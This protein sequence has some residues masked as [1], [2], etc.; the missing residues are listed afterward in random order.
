MSGKSNAPGP[1]ATPNLRRR[2]ISRAARGLIAAIGSDTRLHNRVLRGLLDRHLAPGVLCLV[3]FADH[4]LYVDPRDDKVALKLLSGRPWQRRELETAIALL[5]QAGRLKPDSVFIDVGANI[6]SQTVYAMRSGA[7]TRAIAIEP[8]P[9]NFEILKRNLAINAL[10]SR[11]T[12]LCAAASAAAG[13]L[14]LARHGKNFGAH[15]VEPGFV[16]H[17]A[18]SISV[19]ADTLDELVRQQN[20]APDQ[21]GLVK[22]DVEGHEQAVI[23]GMAVLRRA[24]VPILVEL[25]AAP[26]DSDRIAAFKSLFVPGYQ[27]VANITNGSAPVTISELQWQTPQ[28]DLLIY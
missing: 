28:A 21:V 23:A 27:W 14:Q 9:H 11:V 22:I 16:A 18:R 25:T 4:T 24:R 6:G 13:S 7:F 15:S 3:P 17:P 20:L 2:L 12:P 8:D 5:R 10:E 1:L 26:A 19:T